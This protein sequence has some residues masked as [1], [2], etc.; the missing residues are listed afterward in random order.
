M[1]VV[2]K[3][4]I[5]CVGEVVEEEEP[6]YTVGGNV[7]WYR[8]SENSMEFSQRTKDRI[9][10]WLSSS[11]LSYIYEKAKNIISKRYMHP[12]VHSSVIYNC[13]NVK[14]PKCAS[15]DKCIKNMW[16][17]CTLE[18]YSAIKKEWNLAIYSSM[19]GRGGCYTKWNKSEKDIIGYHLYV[20]SK[21]YSK[22]ANITKTDTQRE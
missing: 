7:N 6:F 11:T 22:L 10:I 15:V 16:Y 12:N 20:E 1:T 9:S 5:I 14:Q 4:Q 21:K 3:T 13:Q 17:R 19:D 18:Y 2:E 8:H